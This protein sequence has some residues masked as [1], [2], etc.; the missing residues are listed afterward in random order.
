M[1]ESEPTLDAAIETLLSLPSGTVFEVQGH[2]DSQGEPGPN[3]ELSEARATAVVTYLTD[4]GVD[5]DMLVPVGYG[6]TQ[7]KVDP[8]ETPEDFAANR[9]IE[10]VDI[11]G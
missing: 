6:E 4:G 11:S 2:T 5:P 1:P 8:E 10:F 9:R 7:L 3:Q